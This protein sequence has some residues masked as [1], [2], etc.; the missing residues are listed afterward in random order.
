MD[1]RAFIAATAATALPVTGIGPALALQS[2]STGQIDPLV[3]MFDRWLNARREWSQL[4]EVHCDW[5]TPEMLALSDTYFAAT[6][7]ITE[8]SAVTL[9]V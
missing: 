7:E 6:H 3:A 4:S 1:R 2:S 9:Q 8:T 5:D